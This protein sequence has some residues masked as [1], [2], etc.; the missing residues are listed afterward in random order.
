MVFGKARSAGKLILSVPKTAIKGTVRVYSYVISPW[1]GRNCRYHPTCSAY[2]CE[3]LDR[4]GVLKGLVLSAARI[5][6]CHPY[7]KRDYH[8][9]VP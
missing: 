1:L 7:A 6:R 9:P 5:L 3:A 2:T 4:H 8:D